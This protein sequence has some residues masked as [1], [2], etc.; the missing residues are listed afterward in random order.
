[1][2]VNGPVDGR[3]TLGQGSFDRLPDGYAVEEYF[4][5]GMA[6]AFGVSESGEVAAG[7]SAPFVTRIVVARPLDAGRFNGTVAVEWLNVS[8]GTDAAPDWTYLHRELVREGYAWIGVSAQRGGLEGTGSGI[9]GML[10]VKLADPVRYSAIDHPGDTYAFDIFAQCAEAGC[11]GT[12]LPG[13]VVQ[14]ILA[15]GESQSAG[16][17]TTFANAIDPL[18]PAFDGYLIHSRFRGA[19]PLDGS[20]VLGAA[21]GVADDADGVTIAAGMR[22][23]VLMFITETDLLAPGIGYLAARQ[24]DTALI[25]T[26]EVAGTAH[27]DSYTLIGNAIDTGTAAIADLAQAFVPMDNFFGQPLDRPIN[28]APQHH[29]VLQ[30]A[31]SALRVWVASGDAPPSAAPLVVEAGA[32]VADRYGNAT[33]GVRSPWVDAPMAK[34]SG[35]GQSGG[36]FAMLFGSTGLFDAARLRDIYPGGVADYITQFE[37]ATD[38]AIAAGHLRPAD[39][40]EIL[41][42]AAFDAGRR[43]LAH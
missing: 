6:K 28:A 5:S 1:M 41:D 40:S 43:F 7:R 17:L 23:P 34:L 15:I 9:P 25:R 38:H 18:L 42:L 26:W 22:V 29:Y 16:F 30:A 10:P 4:I 13:F 12:I 27:A 21:L 37:A 31:L 3:I 24:P 11:T 32:L 36:G 35:F 39:R 19:V 8:G 33:G 20:Y 14:H 2:Q